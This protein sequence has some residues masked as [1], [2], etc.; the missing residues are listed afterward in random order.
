VAHI[1]KGRT[2]YYN[3]QVNPD[4][5]IYV[6]LNNS[7]LTEIFLSGGHLPSKTDND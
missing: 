4:E 3:I 1:N 5:G 7:L 2:D 6:A